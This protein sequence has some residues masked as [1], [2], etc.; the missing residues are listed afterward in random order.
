MT[1]IEKLRLEVRENRIPSIFTKS[2]VSG[3]GIDDPNNNLSN[4]DKK[5]IG[6]LNK[7]VLVS[8]E[9]SGDMYYTFDEKIFD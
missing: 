3:A 6:S 8:K 4:Y 1:F 7:K 2:D 9:I 5:N